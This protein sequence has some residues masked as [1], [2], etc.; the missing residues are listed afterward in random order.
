[1]SDLMLVNAALL[2]SEVRPAL[3]TD[4][5][6]DRRGPTRAY[7]PPQSARAHYLY[8]LCYTLIETTHNQTR[9]AALLSATLTHLHYSTAP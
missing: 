6:H 2:L 8:P 7:T 9:Y 1:M 5:I 3:L 4:A